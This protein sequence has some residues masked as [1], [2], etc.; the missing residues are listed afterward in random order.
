MHFTN[1]SLR[2]SLATFIIACAVASSFALYSIALAATAGPLDESFVGPLASWKSVK[3]YGAKGDGTTDDTAA[4][5]AALNDLKN[6]QT[7]SWSVLYFPSGTYKITQ[8]LTT[9]RSLH[10][11]YH[12]AQIIG[13]DPNTT[14]IVWAGASGGT[15]FSWDA[16]YDKI[17]RLTF[18]GKGL[19]GRGLWRIG[20]FTTYS[21][22]SDTIFKDINVCIDLGENSG[23]GIA[24]Q[25]I[26]RDR[27]YR[28]RVGV[29]TWNW[30]TL[31]VYIWH[32]Y[33]ED[34]WNPIRNNAG[35]W[36]AYDNRFVRSTGVD[37]ASGTNSEF[38]AVNN[39]SLGSKAFIGPAQGN[40]FLQGN[41][42][43][44]TTD[45]PVDLVSTNPTTMIDNVFQSPA[46]KIGVRLGNQDNTGQ[47]LSVGNTFATDALWPIQPIQRN[48]NHGTGGSYQYGSTIEMATDGDRQTAARL[49]MWTDRAGVQ[50]NAPQGTKKTAT[51]YAMSSQ[52][53]THSPLG[54]SPADWVLLG[55]NDWGMTWTTL[56][57]RTGETFG[58][59]GVRKVYPISNPGAYS[60]Y[61]LVIKKNA[62]GDV[63]PNGGWVDVVELELLDSN[64]S[65]FQH[66]PASLTT[67]ADEYWGHFYS[68]QQTVVPR[69]S[70]PIPASLAPFDFAP[71]RSAQ[72]I[73]VPAFTG[74]AIQSAIDQ[75]AALP[76]GTN[77]IVHLRK[78]KYLVTSTIAVPAKI[79]MTIVGDGAS[80]NST[81][82]QWNTTGVG[83][84]M[85]L[86]GPSHVTLHDMYIAG[87]ATADGLLIDTADQ[88]G[89]RVYGY[90]VLATGR[91]AAGGQLVD[92]AFDING[93]DQSD[94][95]I[96]ASGMSNMLTG[97]R[98]T[99]GSLRSN[100]QNAPGRT[101]FLSGGSS[102]GQRLFDVKNGGQL[103]A[104]AWWYE[105]NWPYTDA[106]VNL[107]SS[108]SLAMASMR[109]AD[110]PSSFPTIA[111]SNFAGSYALFG[112]SISWRPQALAVTG[113]GSATNVLTFANGWPYQITAAAMSAFDQTNPA[114]Q[115]AMILNDQGNPD[116]T[117]KV[118][119]A[120]PSSTFVQNQLALLRTIQTIGAVAGPAGVTDV[121]L[122]RII[123]G[124]GDN[125]VAVRIVGG[126]ASSAQGRAS[127]AQELSVE[128]RACITGAVAK[129]P[130]VAALKIE[131]SRAIEGRLLEQPQSQGRRQW[132]VYRVKVE[133]DVSVAGQR[134]TYVFNC[135]HSGQATVIQ[136]L[137]MR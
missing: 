99:G 11:D 61:E 50:W 44:G 107:N 65:A 93:V 16:W 124:G 84:V 102:G 43:Y 38:S 66:D 19:A 127:S 68:D 29:V 120:R 35:D 53:S 5:Q 87:G 41:K 122:L 31:D 22:I 25:M 51:S 4:M 13:Q 108:G 23:G 121:K 70:I 20:G 75:A 45:M 24:E 14:S 2:W 26:L 82:I 40:F 1:R 85:W 21:E 95:Q 76:A 15:M 78:G 58:G 60:S 101:S 117:S 110:G 128:D 104:T 88:V 129:L 90:E 46:G 98:V 39:V 113:N 119:N 71:V 116:I 30:N 89:G 73:E 105:G 109:I 12:G 125:R 132:S 42:V 96:N 52:P 34:N 74:A 123:V 67:G 114:G 94:V 103:V 134:S 115:V 72:V 136:P 47:T 133:I 130:Q 56:D 48:M 100:G 59:Y 27:F 63:T 55:S 97:V 36:D 91:Y 86:K 137:G 83:P 112:S 77:P 10:N 81:T 126:R 3:D 17:S 131:G 49:G 64:N 54:L 9:T 7:N 33:F 62:S 57:T 79:P 135:I 32:S 37:L 80:E 69:T 28:C 111:V 8:T 6:V 106:M 92:A 18:D 118:M